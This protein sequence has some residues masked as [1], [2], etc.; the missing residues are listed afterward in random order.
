MAADAAAVAAGLLGDAA[1]H[2]YDPWGPLRRQIGYKMPPG[3]KIELCT[4]IYDRD[5][6]FAS[7]NCAYGYGC[8]LKGFMRKG[9]NCIYWL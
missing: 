3:P 7:F 5:N 1:D 2:D 4:Q 9:W 8:Q 6:C